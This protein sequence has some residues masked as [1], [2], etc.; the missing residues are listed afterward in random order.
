MLLSLRLHTKRRFMHQRFWEEE[1]KAA[2]Y[3]AQLEPHPR[4][5]SVSE[6]SWHVADVVLT[7]GDHFPFLDPA[8][9]LR[10]AVLHDKM[11]L[12]TGDRNPVGRD[13]TGAKTH[14]FNAARRW[15]KDR[16]EEVAIAR[17]LGGMRPAARP[18]QARA[19]H[20]ILHGRTVDARFVKA[21]DKFAALAY[22]LVKKRGT[23]TDRHLSFTLRYSEKSLDYFPPLEFHY[24]E[25][26]RRLIRSLARE[27]AA[28]VSSVELM[29]KQSRAQLTLF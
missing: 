27:R 20:E 10:L 11:E 12:F 22:V 3:A 8:N 28:P 7:L 23:M 15:D 4:L 14:A 5:E 26:R 17:Y 21:A 9:A 19:L 29:I 24:E 1:T 18:A 16:A 13:G 25:L 6:H 2:E